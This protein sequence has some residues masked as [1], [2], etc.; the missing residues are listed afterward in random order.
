MAAHFEGARPVGLDGEGVVEV[1]FPADA[2]FNKRKA[3]APEQARA[4]AEALEAVI[5]EQA[6]A[7]LRAARRGGDAPEERRPPS[8]ETIDEDELVER[9]KSEFDAEEVS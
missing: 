6:A 7:R 3:E 8:D 9:L 2:T 4:V 1:G 5:G